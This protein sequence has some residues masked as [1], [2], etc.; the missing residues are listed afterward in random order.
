MISEA[1]LARY[2]QEVHLARNPDWETSGIVG[3]FLT[4]R[5]ADLD[6]DILLVYGDIVFEPAV[7][8]AC[9]TTDGIPRAPG[10]TIPI[11][12]DWERLWRCRMHNIFEDAESLRL[13]LTGRVLEI[14]QPVVDLEE[15]H[16]QFMGIVCLTKDSAREFVG[17]YNSCLTNAHGL[18]P[19]PRV[20]D[21]TRLLTAWIAAGHRVGSAPVHGGWLEVDSLEDLA[22][23]ERLAENGNLKSYCAL[24]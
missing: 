16:G 12:T 13:D 21:T 1:N 6:D 15:V 4:A 20:W 3:S 14:G 7:I 23:Y 11:N 5:P 10:V 8:A 2:G 18:A 24:I 17:F 19:H 22:T 9:L